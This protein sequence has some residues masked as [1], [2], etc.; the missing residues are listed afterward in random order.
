MPKED[1]YHNWRTPCDS[2]RL[3][4]RMS[5]IDASLQSYAR[6]LGRAQTRLN[7]HG[8]N[9]HL[10][11]S[12]RDR[13]EVIYDWPSQ[14]AMIP[15]RSYSACREAKPASSVQTEREY[16]YRSFFQSTNDDHWWAGPVELFTWNLESS[17]ASALES[18]VSMTGYWNTYKLDIPMQ[19]PL[20]MA[21]MGCERKPPLTPPSRGW[22]YG[23]LFHRDYCV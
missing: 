5:D 7:I 2:H 11:R 20:A 4:E 13:H 22:H 18:M 14:A 6:G 1:D 23:W 19:L 12:L 17:S 9:D 3:Q 15:S 16:D 21:M 10:M 8:M